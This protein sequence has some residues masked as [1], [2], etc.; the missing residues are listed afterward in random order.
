M[1]RVNSRSIVTLIKHYLRRWKIQRLGPLLFYV[2]ATLLLVGP[3]LADARSAAIGWEGKD[4]PEYIWSLWHSTQALLGGRNPAL[5]ADLNHPDGYFHE[6]RWATLTTYIT[7]IPLARLAPLTMYNVLVLLGS[8]AT[9]YTTYL[10]AVDITGKHGPALLGGLAMLLFPPRWAHVLGGHLETAQT[11]WYPLSLLTLRRLLMRPNLKHATSNAIVWAL[12]AMNSLPGTAYILLPLALSYTPFQ[13]F[14]AARHQRRR[15]VMRFMCLSAAIGLLIVAPFIAPLTKEILREATWLVEEGD[16]S[17]SVDLVSL[18]AP[19]PGAPIWHLLDGPPRIVS[20][21]IASH[22]QETMGYL[23]LIPCVLSL[24]AVIGRRSRT[25][26]AWFGVIAAIAAGL[27][28]GPVLRIG[29]DVLIVNATDSIR[30]P[31]I[32]P[33]KLLALLP[34]YSVGRTPGRFLLLTGLLLSLLTAAGCAY[35]VEKLEAKSRSRILVLGVLMSTLSLDNTVI[36]PAPLYELPDSSAV[37]M[38]AL[39]ARG[40][41]LNV[42]VTDRQANQEGLYYQINHGQPISGGYVHRSLS[43]FP[44]REEMTDW[45]TRPPV[46]GVLIPPPS[47]PDAV[48]A[49][50]AAEVR[51]VIL[52]KSYAG[53]IVSWESALTQRLG[54]A[55][56]SDEHTTIFGVPTQGV[57]QELTLADRPSRW[58]NATTL[59]DR[60]ARW[61]SDDALT[62]GV[63]SPVRQRVDL[64]VTATALDRRIRLLVVLNGREQGQIIVGPLATYRASGLVLGIGYNSISIRGMDPCIKTTVDPRC[65]INRSFLDEIVDCNAW[66]RIERCVNVLMQDLHVN[67]IDATTE[68]S[69]SPITL[70]STLYPTC[71]SP[72][73]TISLNWTGRVK[74]KLVAEPHAFVHLIADDGNAVAQDDRVPNL[75]WY[76]YTEWQIGDW[77]SDVFTL[78]LPRD[79]AT[80]NYRL[81]MGIY[82]YP[83]LVRWPVSG[84]KSVPALDVLEVGV[85]NVSSTCP[86]DG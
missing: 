59:H 61:L 51:Y 12:A 62:I 3:G 28:L 85:L 48:S 1:P 82:S 23:G 58:E 73:G 19:P 36:W 43:T 44:G 24:L 56:S 70:L 45:A 52:H 27:A 66:D 38:L 63:H 67:P 54:P 57:E 11:Y 33:Y 5:M 79:I 68:S 64:T 60:P 50:Q 20:R 15:Q 71:G 9:G 13:L 37:S 65:L 18:L 40:G 46:A 86:S 2:L 74:A 14:R 76:P 16:T 78:N 32:L 25:E 7:A 49:L 81:M 42:P 34:G 80:G 6:V 35:M 39:R 17:F 29:G 84:P 53:D 41:V 4:Q 47:V 22:P 21:A 83:D 69:I 26:L 72:G 8:A 75:P 55:I 77:I 31:V 10:L 30:G